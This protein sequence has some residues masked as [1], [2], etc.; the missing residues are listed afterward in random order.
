MPWRQ[1]HRPIHRG[2]GD[3][4]SV[5]TYWNWEFFGGLL[6]TPDLQ[7]ISNPARDTERDSA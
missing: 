3:E 2:T 4:I 5:E 1:N 6:L 7:Y